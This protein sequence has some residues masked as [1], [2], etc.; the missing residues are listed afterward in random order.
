M[1][2]IL[3][4]SEIIPGCTFVATGKTPEEVF[5]H[6]SEHVRL[7]HKFHS[8]SPEVIAVIRGTVLEENSGRT[9]HVRARNGAAKP[10]GALATERAR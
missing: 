5:E 7:V 4:C 6:A 8:M 9:P 2:K 1:A 10:L 3:R